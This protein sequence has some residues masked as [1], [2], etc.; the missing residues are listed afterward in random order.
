MRIDIIGTAAERFYI[1]ASHMDDVLKLLS[2][3]LA[4]MKIG[5]SSG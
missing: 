4:A 2:K 5:S 1:P 3:K